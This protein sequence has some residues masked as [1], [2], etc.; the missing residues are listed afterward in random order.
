M[1]AWHNRLIEKQ[2]VIGV[3]NET[4]PFPL[5]APGLCGA[6]ASRNRY[7]GWLQQQRAAVSIRRPTDYAGPMS[8]RLRLLLAAGKRGLWRCFRRR[9]PIQR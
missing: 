1:A 8:S 7:S 6:G 3:S 9:A 4:Q 5:R 2:D